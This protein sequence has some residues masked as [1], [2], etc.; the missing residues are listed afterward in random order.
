M[1]HA[2]MGSFCL[3][4]FLAGCGTAPAESA[5]ESRPRPSTA[6]VTR[7][8]HFQGRTSVLSVLQSR[9]AGMQ[10]QRMEGG[11]PEITLRGRTS[12]RGSNNPVI[13]VEGSRSANTCILEMLDPQD[14]DRVEVY[15]SGIAPGGRPPLSPT[16]LILVYLRR[17]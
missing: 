16:G 1:K 7:A 3:A 8:E 2:W 4:A 9:I 15:P 6:R 17:A 10:V 14:I 12:L 13:Y 5:D 11:C